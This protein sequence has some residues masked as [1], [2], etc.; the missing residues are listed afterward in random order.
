MRVGHPS[1]G[2]A[3]LQGVP[4]NDF[5][6]LPFLQTFSG[7]VETGVLPMDEYCYV[8]I[9]FLSLVCLVFGFHGG[10]G[11]R[12]PAQEGGP[13]SQVTTQHCSTRPLIVL[14]NH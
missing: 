9:H 1:S 14:P 4:S 6:V 12:F 10:Q 8:H 13:C 7:E 11:M 3:N 5:K 2:L